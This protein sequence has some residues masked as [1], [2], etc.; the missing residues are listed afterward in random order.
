MSTPSQL[1]AQCITI[2]NPT[3]GAPDSVICGPFPVK[4]VNGVCP[5]NNCF[6]TPGDVIS[7][8]MEYVFPFAGIALLLVIFASGY[9]L[10][11]SRGEPAKI[12]AA[13]KRITYGLLGFGILIIAYVVVK[14]L[15]Y[16][17]GF[18]S[19]V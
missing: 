10:I 17:L 7:R 5:S 9:Q 4:D 19:P 2:L 14:T 3:P 18:D 1:L 16:I 8:V 15:S 12:Q 11:M 6:E 13:T